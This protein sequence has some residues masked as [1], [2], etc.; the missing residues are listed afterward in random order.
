M[1]KVDGEGWEAWDIVWKTGLELEKRTE[2]KI[3][4]ADGAA[5]LPPT[6]NHHPVNTVHTTQILLHDEMTEIISC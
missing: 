2:V 4:A 6:L 5:V 3:W 1:G